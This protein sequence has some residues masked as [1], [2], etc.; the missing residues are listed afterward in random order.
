VDDEATILV[1]YPKAQGIIE[2]S[3]NWPYSRKDLEVY[4]ERGSAIAIGG[5][6]LRVRIPDHRE[7]ETRTPAE[8]PPDERDSGVVPDGR[9]SRQTQ[10]RRSFVAREQPDR[11]G[12]SH[13]RTRVRSHRQKGR[14]RSALSLAPANKYE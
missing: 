4:A 3:W 8:L 9:G 13:G 6:E 7:E 2:G 10:A 12:D 1:E 5:N 11:H 14:D